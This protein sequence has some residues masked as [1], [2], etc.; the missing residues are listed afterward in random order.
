[1]HSP[2]TRACSTHFMPLQAHLTGICG[3][4]W[5]P[6]WRWNSYSVCAVLLRLHTTYS[7]PANTT[8]NQH[9]WRLQC[10]RGACAM[11]TLCRPVITCPPTCL[12]YSWGTRAGGQ[13]WA[14]ASSERPAWREA[15][16]S[17]WNAYAPYAL[18]A[19]GRHWWWCEKKKKKII[20][21]VGAAGA[22]QNRALCLQPAGTRR[23]LGSR[24]AQYSRCD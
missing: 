15:K 11:P 9:S 3:D 24:R 2:V 12:P 1:M 18:R 8:I 21:V 4:W 16:D 14:A 6:F 13:G 20:S 17:R 10:D 7:L 22:G 23:A 19:A 5:A